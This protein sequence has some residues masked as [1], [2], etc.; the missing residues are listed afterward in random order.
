MNENT[1]PQ[2]SDIEQAVADALVSQPG[3]IL[4]SLIHA[5]GTEKM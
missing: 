1:L 2:G 4:L 5:K 3:Y